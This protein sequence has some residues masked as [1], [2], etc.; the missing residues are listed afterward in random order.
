MSM[1]VGLPYAPGYYE[2]H[3]FVIT[4]TAD[5]FKLIEH[6]NKRVHLLISCF[7]GAIPLQP[8]FHMEQFGGGEAKY[9]ANVNSNFEL[10]WYRHFVL[11]NSAVFVSGFNY[12]QVFNVTEISYNMLP[13]LE[14]ENATRKS[15][16]LVNKIKGIISVRWTNRR[17]NNNRLSV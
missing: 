10:F 12:P 9:V 16:T 15:E 6:N 13:H 5:G 14:Q 11:V 1:Q 17:N 2:R 4:A 3:S 8:A 7:S